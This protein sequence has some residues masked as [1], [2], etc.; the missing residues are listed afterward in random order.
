MTINP[1][2]MARMTALPMIFLS[3]V[4]GCAIVSLIVFLRW[5]FSKKA[6]PFHPEGAK[7]F[8]KDEFLRL[9]AIFLPYALLMV[10]LK[11]YFGQYHPELLSS[12]YMPLFFLSIILFRRLAVF[13]PFV[14]DAGNRIDAARRQQR[15]AHFSS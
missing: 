14:R 3:L 1:D 2:P 11:F 8:F 5:Y 10:A 12:P 4:I 15:E 6:W 7:G 9:G 13:V